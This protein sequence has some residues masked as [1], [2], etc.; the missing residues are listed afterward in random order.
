MPQLDPSVFATQLFWLA[1]TFIPLYL[2]L[3]KV[4]LPRITDIRAARRERIEDDLEKA[5]T[6]REEAATAL[7]EYEAAIATA[8]ARAQTAI[9]EAA[10]E[11]AEEATRQREALAERLAEETAEA[12]QR[13]ADETQRVVAD[14]GTMAADLALRAAGRLTREPISQDE[15][16]AAVEAVM[17]GGR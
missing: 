4:A 5:E 16:N 3:W 7:A 2:I 14:I 1:L 15:A 8:T 12:E 6:L 13:I 9:R 11:M 10:H 17:Q